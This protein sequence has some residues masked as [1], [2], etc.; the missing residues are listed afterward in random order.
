MLVFHFSSLL[1]DSSSSQ[2]TAAAVLRCCRP[3]AA[4]LSPRS[5]VTRASPRKTPKQNMTA[6]WSGIFFLFFFFSLSFLSRKSFCRFLSANC[7]LCK[8]QTREETFLLFFYCFFFFFAVVVVVI[9]CFSSSTLSLLTATVSLCLEVLKQDFHSG[10]F[11]FRRA[12]Q[13]LPQPAALFLLTSFIYKEVEKKWCW[14]LKHSGD[15]I[16][17]F[18]FFR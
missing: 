18:F 3:P 16:D 1:P 14:I 11:I 12:N 9:T 6:K 7:E 17:F 10:I 15:M 8:E 5:R 4:P 2:L 13:I